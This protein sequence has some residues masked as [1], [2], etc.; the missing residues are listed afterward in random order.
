MIKQILLSFLILVFGAGASFAA[1]TCYTRA[2][3]EAEQGLRI[4]SELMV[5]GLNCIKMNLNDGTNLYRRYN[6]FTKE[7]IDIFSGYEGRMLEYFKRR[8]DKNP[9]ASLNTL[10]TLM[11]NNI[12]NS[13]ARMRPDQFCNRYAGRIFKASSMDHD[14]LK[15]WA[16][17]IYP[18]HP[19]SNPICEH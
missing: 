16:S 17:T 7:N 14:T 12:S 5:I 18:S 10:R 9:E 11:A 4:H 3:A 2:E 1:S 19:V 13:A 15:K 8:G 6:E